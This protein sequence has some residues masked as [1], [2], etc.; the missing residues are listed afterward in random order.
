MGGRTP[1]LMNTGLL[2]VVHPSCDSDSLCQP[3]LGSTAVPDVS[4]TEPEMLP[5][6][7]TCNESETTPAAP[8][9]P[10][11]QACTAVGVP[12]PLTWKTFSAGSGLEVGSRGAEITGGAGDAGVCASTTTSHATCALSAQAPGRGRSARRT[13][14]GPL[15]QQQRLRAVAADRHRAL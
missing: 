12:C 11:S 13:R 9:P 3:G 2:V 6:A 10:W 14:V 8:M 1:T 7:S 15:R 4:T 5:S